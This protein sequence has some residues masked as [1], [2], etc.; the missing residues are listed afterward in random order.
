MTRSPLLRQVV[1]LALPVQIM[2]A[3]F[4]LLRGH[5]AP[6]GGFVA[7]L[8]TTA[9]VVLAALT[10]GRPAVD[11]ALGPIVRPLPVLG[12][13]VALGSGLVAVARG[14]G[15][16]THGHHRVV[17]TPHLAITLSTTL[18]FDVGVYLVVVGVTTVILATL[19]KGASS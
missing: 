19:A 1:A 12:L 14:E 8:V 9:A 4:L 13:A 6:G 15:F 2:F 5:D 16:L 18:I 10:F 7:G 3:A 17:V 11:R